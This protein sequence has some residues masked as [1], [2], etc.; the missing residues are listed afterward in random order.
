M[1]K[2]IEH[3]TRKLV[4][5]ESINGTTGE[6]NLAD[7]V[8]RWPQSFPYF[9][10]SP[11]NVW[12]QSIPNDS[13]GRKNIFAFLK[14][15]SGSNKT[16]IYHAHIDTVGID[17]F[18]NMKANALDSDAL[19]TYFKEYPFN[20]DVQK[21]A[22]SGDYL[23]GR[24]S[25]DMQSGIAVHLANLLYFTEHLDELPGNILFMANSDEES[26]HKGVKSSISEINR[27]KVEENLDYIVA[28]NNGIRRKGV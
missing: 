1:A 2:Q 10:K 3:I 9:V 24:G 6:V 13:L 17:D 5:T 11:T 21:D 18:G 20:Q 4:Q 23:F 7:A 12:E 27:L 25:V 8:K 22:L 16:I 19:E 14:S 28:I 26:Q 15:P